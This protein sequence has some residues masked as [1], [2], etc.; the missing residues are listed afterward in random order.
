MPGG[1]S[2]P[3][4]FPVGVGRRRT[5]AGWIVIDVDSVLVRDAETE[6]STVSEHAL[7]HP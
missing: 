2:T 5:L 4:G 7:S 1:S 6:A 3:A